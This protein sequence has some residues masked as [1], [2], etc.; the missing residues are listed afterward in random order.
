MKDEIRDSLSMECCA[1]DCDE[2]TPDW[3]CRKHWQ[4]VRMNAVDN[5]IKSLFKAIKQIKT[6]EKEENN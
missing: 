4:E 5:L 1:K 2:K 3:F 6:H